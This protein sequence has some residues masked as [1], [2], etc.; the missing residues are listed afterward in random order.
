M[1]TFNLT[2]VSEALQDVS[3]DDSG[4]SFAGLAKKWE[5]EADGKKFNVLHCLVTLT[6]IYFSSGL[7]TSHQQL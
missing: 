5:S 6:L 7:G 4:V 2:N 3:D 1:T